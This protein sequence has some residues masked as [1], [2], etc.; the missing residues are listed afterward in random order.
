LPEHGFRRRGSQND[1][2]TDRDEEGIS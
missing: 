2:E 1:A